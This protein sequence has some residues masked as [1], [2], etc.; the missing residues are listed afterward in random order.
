MAR[1][2]ASDNPADCAIESGLVQKKGLADFRTRA[3]R[4]ASLNHLTKK[5]GGSKMRARR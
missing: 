1:Q 2:I 4:N 3:R 5:Q